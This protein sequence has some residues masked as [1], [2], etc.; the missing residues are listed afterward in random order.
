V[1]DGGHDVLEH[2]I[3]THCA[4]LTCDPAAAK[5]GLGAAGV[6]A[7]A[8]AGGA[9]SSAGAAT[10]VSAKTRLLAEAGRVSTGRRL[11][12]IAVAFVVLLLA[13]FY[14]GVWVYRRDLRV[15]A[16][17]RRLDGDRRGK[18]LMFWKRKNK[19]KGY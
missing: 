2:L 6:G 10:A 9:G 19:E 11:Y 18:T 8:G 3:A 1:I 15:N 17:L 14:L 4:P 7:G 12:Y 5:P 16:D 13:V